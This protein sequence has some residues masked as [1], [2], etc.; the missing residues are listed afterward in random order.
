MRFCA[1][2]EPV[3]RPSPQRSGTR[4]MGAPKRRRRITVGLR[5]RRSGRRQC[6]LAPG[7]PSKE[8]SK[9]R[10]RAIC[11]PHSGAYVGF[12]REPRGPRPADSRA[13]DAIGFGD[14]NVAQMST[15]RCG[16]WGPVRKTL[17]HPRGGHHD[18]QAPASRFCAI[19]CRDE[20]IDNLP[21]G[22]VRST[23]SRTTGAAGVCSPGR[24]VAAI[25]AR[26]CSWARGCRSLGSTCTRS[27][28]PRG[29]GW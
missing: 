22:P 17:L 6:A 18:A 10:G 21:S 23:L 8:P 14:R 19:G 13:E 4:R 12:F 7:V 5:W 2:G 15:A 9:P 26:A 11:L 20:Q 16:L 3:N 28:A 25:Q 1:R 29:S 24:R 27:S